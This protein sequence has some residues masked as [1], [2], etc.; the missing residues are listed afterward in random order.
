MIYRQAA[1]GILKAIKNA[2][3]P[4]LISHEQPDGD[5]LGAGLALSHFLDKKKIP[6]KYF[7]IDKP[8]EYFSYLP[9]I[10][11]VISDK[12]QIDLNEHDMIITVDCADLNRT[13]LGEEIE[14]IKDRIILINIDHHQTNNLF[15]HHNLVM[16]NA[17]STSEIVYQFL[18]FAQIEPD[19]Y[20]ATNLLT[21][22]ISD[23]TN[24]T[25]S[26]T[27][28]E[29][30]EI[31]A[32]LLNRGARISHIIKSLTQ[33]KSLASLK[34]WGKIL[35][36]LEFDRQYNFA[37]TIITQ[38]DL[39]EDQISKEELDGLANF[40]NLLQE[41]EFVLL[42]TEESQDFIKGSFRTTKDHIDVAELAQT[43]SGGGH[44][45][46]AGFKIERKS[47]PDGDW[48]NFIL[49]VIINRLKS[50]G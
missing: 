25:N 7:C 23:T 3:H 37:Y 29:S 4:L 24:F 27:T 49:N 30:L 40:L 8:A 42:L 11:V 50:K 5:T 18:D 43:L 2:N 48:K 34:I 10:E 35:S 36:R 14:Q 39:A 16:A 26:A 22:I 33:N 28:K 38:K 20:M 9:K 6:H 1:F 41:A 13:A 31:A 15:G 47:I 32:K 17:S 44:K 19:K 12:K 46:A 21:G 45:K